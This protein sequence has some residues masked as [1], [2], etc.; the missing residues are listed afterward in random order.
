MSTPSTVTRTARNAS[1]SDS[2]STPKKAAPSVLLLGFDW[3]TN[4]SCILGLHPEETELAVNEIVPT[5]V[6]YAKDG[7]VND[8]LPDNASILYGHQAIQYR[9]HLNLKQPMVDGVLFD[10]ASAR[11]FALHLRTLM[12][13]EPGTE[14][15][16]VIGVPANADSSA[17]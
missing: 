2:V 16:A 14:I 13:V 7:I 4:T 9:L 1:A 11:D 3:G 5:V 17:R 12:K 6:G 10:Q 8:L 15:R